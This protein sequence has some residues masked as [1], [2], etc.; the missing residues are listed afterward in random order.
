MDGKPLVG[1]AVRCWMAG[2]L[3]CLLAI[4]LAGLLAARLQ[5]LAKELEGRALQSCSGRS[6]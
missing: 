1:Q 6:K 5:T 2:L 4:Q 3:S